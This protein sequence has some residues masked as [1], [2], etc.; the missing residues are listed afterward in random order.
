MTF[1]TDNIEI[2]STFVDGEELINLD[3][4]EAADEATEEVEEEADE[5]SEEVEEEADEASEEAAEEE[6]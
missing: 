5:A 4:N 3:P 6:N 2:E 1:V